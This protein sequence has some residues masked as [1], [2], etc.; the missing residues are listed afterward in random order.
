MRYDTSKYP[1][2]WPKYQPYWYAITRSQTA[3]VPNR[4]SIDWPQS[5]WAPNYLPPGSPSFQ[6]YVYPKG[7]MPNIIND[8]YVN[9]YDA[10]SGAGCGCS[11]YGDAGCDCGCSDCK[12]RKNE[13]AVG[14]PWWG[15]AGIIG[16]GF[17]AYKY[18]WK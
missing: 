15:W 6:P 5:Q 17:L 3:P 9:E 12:A 16:G 13:G 7:P 4:Q 10:L 18:L 11:G 1:A 2:Y 8:L 14:I